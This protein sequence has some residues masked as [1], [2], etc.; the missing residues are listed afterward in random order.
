MIK[1]MI[2]TPEVLPVEKR[3]GE[4]VFMMKS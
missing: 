3:V 4:D 2:K 1:K